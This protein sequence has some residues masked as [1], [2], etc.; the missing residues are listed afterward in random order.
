M[1]KKLWIPA[2]V[3]AALASFTAIALLFATSGGSETQVSGVVQ[4]PSPSPIVSPTPTLSPVPIS[5]PMP[6]PTPTPFPTPVPPPPPTRF[7][8]PAAAPPS[9]PPLPLPALPPTPESA[10]IFSEQTIL[11]LINGYLILNDITIT[12]STGFVF[13]LT[14]D[15]SECLSS[16][17]DYVWDFKCSRQSTVVDPLCVIR[18]VYCTP[19]TSTLENGFLVFEDTLQVVQ[20]L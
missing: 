16:W 6:T 11:N 9:P 15:I 2:I 20:Y 18:A 13:D 3:L 10:P 17:A 12:T 5:T 4:T 14:W 19:G 1:H 8:P 7:V